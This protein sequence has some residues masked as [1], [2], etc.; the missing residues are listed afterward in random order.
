[1][2]L[3]VSSPFSIPMEL[4]VGL[5]RLAV[6]VP[7]L[8]DGLVLRQVGF[9]HLC[10]ECAFCTGALLRFELSAVGPGSGDER[11]G[12]DR[13][14][15]GTVGVRVC[16]KESTQRG[17]GLECS[18]RDADERGRARGGESV[19]DLGDVGRCSC[20]DSVACH[21]AHWIDP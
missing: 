1:M 13:G 9:L 4:R 12:E 11:S 8:C 5:D 17:L 21:V 19:V 14:E 16:P 6:D 10:V 7:A 2:F 15:V 20:L 18:G 3:I